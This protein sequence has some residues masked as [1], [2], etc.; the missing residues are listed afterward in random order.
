MRVLTVLL[1][2]SVVM[3]NGVETS[4]EDDM[5]KALV[6]RSEEKTDPNP[7]AQLGH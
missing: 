4:T 7:L 5:V 6:M 1:G 2:E 3:E